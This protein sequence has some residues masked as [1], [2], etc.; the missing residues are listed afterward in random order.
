MIS[1][2]AEHD[3]MDKY[4]E[5]IQSLMVISNAIKTSGHCGL[6]V[7]VSCDHVNVLDFESEEKA[8]AYM[9]TNP[10]EDDENYF[11]VSRINS[12]DN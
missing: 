8:Q 10:I 6:V 2:N 11:K 12:Q 1:Q 4:G 3:N 5:T 7:R 9:D